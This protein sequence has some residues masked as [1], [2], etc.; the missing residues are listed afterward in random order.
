MFAGKEH[1][2]QYMAKLNVKSQI[3]N[4]RVS[5]NIKKWMIPRPGTIK[6]KLKYKA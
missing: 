1:S 3:P 4:Q 2:L 5:E 6:F